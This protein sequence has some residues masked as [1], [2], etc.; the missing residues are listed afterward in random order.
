MKTLSIDLII[1]LLLVSTV[2]MTA[3]I[4]LVLTI[5]TSL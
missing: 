1:R 4:L 5:N 2:A 3:V